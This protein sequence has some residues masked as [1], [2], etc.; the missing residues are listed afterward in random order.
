MLPAW[1][2]H[3]STCFGYWLYLITIQRVFGSVF[4]GVHRLDL[5]IDHAEACL[6]H[7]LILVH[8]VLLQVK[9]HLI[10]LVVVVILTHGLP[11]ELRIS[12]DFVFTS[13]H[14]LMSPTTLIELKEIIFELF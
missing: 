3:Q 10:E 14:H 7:F 6:R 13:H 8:L 2:Y 5:K 11:C 9:L 12:G 4:L 1:Y